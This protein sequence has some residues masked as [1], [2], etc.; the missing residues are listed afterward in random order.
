MTAIPRKNTDFSDESVTSKSSSSDSEKSEENSD[1]DSITLWQIEKTFNDSKTLN[2]YIQ[3]E[4]CWST[5]STVHLK[6]SVKTVYRCNLVKCKGEQCNAEIY[7]LKKVNYSDDSDFMYEL[8]R[9]KS[10]HNHDELVSKVKKVPEVLKQKII[11]LYKSRKLP[12]SIQ[13][14]LR[15]DDNISP[16]EQ[17]TIRQI[18]NVIEAFK[19]SQHGKA[20]ITMNQL[21]KF[22]EKNMDI[23]DESLLDKAFVLTF[24][25]S[26]SSERKRYFRF[27]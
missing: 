15:D 4:K 26:P 24:E 7:V 13:Y 17:P 19:Y 18:R 14:E 16:N 6:S 20:P 22:T 23:P 3:M 8:F 12:K 5:R 27:L 1:K 9:K 25:R 11:S 10:Q 21:T 2:Q